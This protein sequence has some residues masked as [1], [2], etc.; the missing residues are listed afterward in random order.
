[1]S[2]M[3]RRRQKVWPCWISDLMKADWNKIV[4]A[5][6]APL[7]SIMGVIVA[8]VG[9]GDPSSESGRR[10]PVGYHLDDGTGVIR[11]VHFL[12][13]A[14]IGQQDRDNLPATLAQAS[15]NVQEPGLRSLAASTRQLLE[16]SR[17]EWP[18]GAT[19]EAVGRLQAG[20]RGGPREFLA[21]NVRRVRDPSAEVDRCLLLE[22]THRQRGD[23]PHQLFQPS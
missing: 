21:Q 17:C 14:R 4:E 11:V 23:Y 3:E 20:F 8:V 13:S 7:F 12:G 5:R 1:V 9:P 18:L 10:R 22:E 2:S 6:A 15:A 19:I 16:D